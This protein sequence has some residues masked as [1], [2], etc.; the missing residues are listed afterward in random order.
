MKKFK[1]A[2]VFTFCINLSHSQE[3]TG[4]WFGYLKVSGMEIPLIFHIEKNDS[5]FYSSM[6]SPKQGAFGIKADRTAFENSVLKISISSAGI[7]YEGTF[8]DTNEIIK[9]TFKQGGMDIPLN[10]SRNKAEGIKASPL[11]PQ[12]PKAPFNYRSE[13]IIFN[14]STDSIEL[15][16]TLTLPKGSKKYPAVILI[17]G[18]GPQNRDSEVFGHKPFLVL[19]DHLTKQGIAV[20]RFDDRGVEESEGDLS[21]ATSK[22]LANDVEAAV[23]FLKS[24]QDI[25]L[26]KIGLLGHSE[27]GLI[28]PM[29]AKNSKDVNF[30]ILL[31]G[32]G[33]RGDKNLLLQK[34]ILEQ[35][36][37]INE[38]T[39]NQGQQIFSGAY[40]LIRNSEE[41][42]E[43]EELQKKLKEYFL[44]Q[45]AGSLNEK[46]IHTLVQQIT[47]PW[48]KFYLKHDP[49]PVLEKTTIP[50]LAL[51]GENDFQ[52]PPVENSIIVKESLQ[53]AGNDNVQIIVF[54]NLNHLFQDST[55]GLPNEYADIEQTIS[56]EVLEAISIW[57]LDRKYNGG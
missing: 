15:A 12:E 51:F 9:G 39:V 52:V 47:S 2:I 24:R 48:I 36:S 25:D 53:K 13:E 57:I 40:D 6:D 26:N 18:S 1:F 21:N 54:D 27:G 4:E 8:N 16:G 20:L 32:Q 42:E 38:L 49:A 33:L 22:N 14:N 35:K 28:A 44:Q 55:T 46:Q 29:V 41:E 19:A 3:I 5:T 11:R 31:A 23:D 37:G 50:V 56:P 30:I 10:L 34:R 43:E 17:S 7:T 45:S